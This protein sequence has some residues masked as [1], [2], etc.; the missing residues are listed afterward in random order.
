METAPPAR[1]IGALISLTLHAWGAPKYDWREWLPRW[2]FRDVNCRD[3]RQEVLIRDHRYRS[4]DPDHGVS[5]ELT[6]DGCRGP[7]RL[8][9]APR[10]T[11]APT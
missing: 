6:P 4:A 10:R 9:R 1:P 8:G 2:A 3:T 7:A 11:P 5:L